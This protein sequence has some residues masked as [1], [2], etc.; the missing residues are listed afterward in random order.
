MII[1]ICTSTG[2]FFIVIHSAHNNSLLLLSSRFFCHTE[3]RDHLSSGQRCHANAMKSKMRITK[4]K[5][6][7]HNSSNTTLQLYALICFCHDGAMTTDVISISI[8]LN[9]LCMHVHIRLN[10]ICRFAMSAFSLC[11][12]SLGRTF[13]PG[14]S[15]AVPARLD[16]L[17]VDV[18]SR[19]S[20]C[21]LPGWTSWCR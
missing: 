1:S 20:F 3:Y 4:K 14:C 17:L 15:L 10:P 21:I 12:H 11:V 6:H 9:H 5:T 16:L 2:K 19:Y 18:V 8:Q 7:T 13:F